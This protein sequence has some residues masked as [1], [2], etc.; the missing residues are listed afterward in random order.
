MRIW[1]G[2]PCSYWALTTSRQSN[3]SWSGQLV[4][5]WPGSLTSSPL[6]SYLPSSQSAECHVTCI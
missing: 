4:C 3:T 2:E 6:Y 1:R 5:S